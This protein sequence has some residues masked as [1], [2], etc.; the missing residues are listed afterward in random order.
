MATPDNK[1]WNLIQK[2]LKSSLDEQEHYA[3]EQW[4]SESESNRRLYQRVKLAWNVAA[5][6]Q[7]RY[8]PDNQAAWERIVREA[9]LPEHET[10]YRRRSV[11]YRIIPFL[12]S[13]A[14]ILFLPLLIGTA[15]LFVRYSE[16]PESPIVSVATEAGQ[17]SH[18]MLKDSTRIWL[19]SDSRLSSVSGH[20]RGE[21]R[22]KLS[23]EAYIET[24]RN[25]SGQLVVVTS[26]KDIRVTG[27][28]FNVRA[29]SEEARVETVLE[30]GQVELLADH[31]QAGRDRLALLRPGQRAV[32]DKASGNLV[33]SDI[34]AFEYT[35]WR[36]GVLVFRNV[37]FDELSDRLEKWFGVEI[38]YHPDQFND[39][40]YSGTFRNR[41]NIEQVLNTVRATTPFEYH[42]ENNR[43][44][45]Y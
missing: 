29:Y 44:T 20:N 22:L 25:R 7:H 19:N 15:I 14:A 23:G 39:G 36:N 9:G 32:F 12:R 8:R 34:N 18:F 1:I 24:P 2:A 38:Q 16:S 5:G 26:H 27:T 10:G 17:R 40:R 11:T 28:S 42:I 21:T 13:A 30:S 33:I 35:A 45:I 41:E 31:G 43:V 3:F 37:S 6:D 4:L